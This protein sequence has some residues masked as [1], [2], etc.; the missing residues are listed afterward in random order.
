MAEFLASTLFNTSALALRGSAFR[1]AIASYA[2]V[3]MCE[4]TEQVVFTD[5]FYASPFNSHTSPQLDDDAAALR[6]DSAAKSAATALKRTFMESTQALLHGD[7]HTGSVMVK[8]T[9]TFVFDC[10][11][12]F[13]GPM[14]FD[15]GAFLGN[16]LLAF[17]AAEGHESSPGERAAQRSW[18]LSCVREIW[19][20]FVG[21]FKALWSEAVKQGTAGE[22]CPPVRAA[23]AQLQH[24]DLTSCD[25]RCS[26][27]MRLRR[28]AALPPCK[29]RSWRCGSVLPALQPPT[30]R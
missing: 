5:P 22:A 10:E 13:Y 12:S 26:A 23:G 15:I 17:F 24:L 3:N 28:R 30:R 25:R 9:S 2:N 4:L 21:R 1:R 7:L 20:Q 18:L 16:L 6:A 11:F 27:P 29:T 8:D 19:V 14:G